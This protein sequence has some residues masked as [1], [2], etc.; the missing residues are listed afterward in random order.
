[1]AQLVWKA[2][3]VAEPVDATAL[4]K[5]QPLPPPSSQVSALLASY[6]PPPS[7]HPDYC[8]SRSSMVDFLG[9][10][11]PNSDGQMSAAGVA[12]SSQ[13][14]PGL[15]QPPLPTCPAAPAEDGGAGP[16]LSNIPGNTTRSSAF[17]RQD[18]DLGDPSAAGSTSHISSPPP[19][20]GA[21]PP[22]SMLNNPNL[23][24]LNSTGDHSTAI[25]DNLDNG[26]TEPSR[27]KKRSEMGPAERQLARQASANQSKKLGEAIGDPQ[28]TVKLL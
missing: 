17:A 27:K 24:Q 19:P 4:A 11:G 10:Q 5:T 12:G 20:T 2:V 13:N 18:S 16:L 8:P 7:P 9:A 21:P 22:S 6:P 23:S 28:D 25:S 3:T 26:S 15:L 14:S 1:M